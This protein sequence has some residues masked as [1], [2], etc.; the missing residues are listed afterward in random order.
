MRFTKTAPRRALAAV[1]IAGALAL[2]AAG[3]AAA[4]EQ[5]PLNEAKSGLLCK[6]GG[7]LLRPT[8]VCSIYDPRTETSTN[9]YT[10]D[11]DSPGLLGL[12]LLGLL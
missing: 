9:P 12:G 4:Q 2:G 6:P 7:S 8:T 1:S 10:E 11:G 5:D 3:P